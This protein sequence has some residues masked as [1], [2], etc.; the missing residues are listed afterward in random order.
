MCLTCFEMAGLSTVCNAHRY[1]SRI[2][3]PGVPAHSFSSSP[4][5]MMMGCK[6][7]RCEWVT[8]ETWCRS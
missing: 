6:L 5:D 2:S 1:R 7:L 3:L 8:K 4:A